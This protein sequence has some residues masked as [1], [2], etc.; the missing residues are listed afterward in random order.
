MCF[1]HWSN[2]LISSQY[3]FWEIYFNFHSR[4]P[5]NLNG[6]VAVFYTMI[7]KHNSFRHQVGSAGQPFRGSKGT[8]GWL[9][10]FSAKRL[11]VHQKFQSLK[12][13]SLKMLFSADI[14]FVSTQ[15]RAPKG[16]REMI[17]SAIVRTKKGVWS[18]IKDYVRGDWQSCYC[19]D[20]FNCPKEL[21]I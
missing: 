14:V 21:Q 20:R 18:Q 2:T 19:R 8:E 3:K 16:Q 11:I 13:R 4:C 12:C 6:W 5:T 7:L 17:Q 10:K 15:E 9:R 1:D